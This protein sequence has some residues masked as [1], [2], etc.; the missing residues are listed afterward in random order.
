[1]K[2]PLLPLAK[3]GRV[4][5]LYVYVSMNTRVQIGH[6]RLLKDIVDAINCD[7]VDV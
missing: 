1:M 3:S 7:M 2:L 5:M 6:F 4:I